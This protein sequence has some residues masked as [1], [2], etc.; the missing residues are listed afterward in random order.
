MTRLFDI[1][2]NEVYLSQYIIIADSLE[3]IRAKA[4]PGF[5][6]CQNRYSKDDPVIVETWI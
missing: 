6:T 3:E 1:G 2:P 4:I 5:M